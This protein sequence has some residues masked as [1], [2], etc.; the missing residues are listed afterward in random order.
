MIKTNPIAGETI[1]VVTSGNAEAVA[2]TSGANTLMPGMPATVG[3]V[4]DATGGIDAGNFID[5]D[6][7]GELLRFNSEDAPLMNLM[8]CAKRVKV[9]SPEV[10][11]YM[12]DEPGASVVTTGA[13][14]G[15]TLSQTILP[16]SSADQLVPRA[17]CT[18]L[19]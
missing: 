7:D 11:H 18:L 4:A 3:A 13:C 16:L 15:G 5:A 17:N 9:N 6:V 8:L 10:D 1:A 2:G 19:V 12:L 14:G